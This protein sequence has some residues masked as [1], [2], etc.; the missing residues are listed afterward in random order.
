MKVIQESRPHGEPF[1]GN[2]ERMELMR[3]SQYRPGRN[4]NSLKNLKRNIDRDPEELREMGR[5]GGIA[6]GKVRKKKAIVHRIMK[7]WAKSY[8]NVYSIYEC[9]FSDVAE[10][11]GIPQ[12][13]EPALVWLVIRILSELKADHK[14]D[15]LSPEALR[16]IGLTPTR[17]GE[18]LQEHER[19]VIDPDDYPEGYID[20]LRTAPANSPVWRELMGL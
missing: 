8:M 12:S 17:A 20:S 11:L 15:L 2:P 10:E 16:D 6:S 19:A 18:I 13:Q 14:Q 7:K 1:S 3:T 5:R 9:T 4:P